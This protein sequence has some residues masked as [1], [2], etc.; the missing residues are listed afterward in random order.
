MNEIKDLFR[1]VLDA[2][3]PPPPTREAMLTIAHTAAARRRVRRA[4]AGMSAVV[5][6]TVA[7]AVAPHVLTPKAELLGAASARQPVSPREHG[8][9]M[10]RTLRTIVPP[11]FTTPSAD[12]YTDGNGSFPVRVT[13]AAPLQGPYGEIV[14]STDVYKGGAGGSAAVEVRTTGK[15]EPLGDLCVTGT[16]VLQS[17]ERGCRVITAANGLRVRFSWRELDGVGR[18]EYAACFHQGGYVLLQQGPAATRPDTEVLGR[19]WTE[20]QLADAVATTDFWPATLG[21]FTR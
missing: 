19:I 16:V 15:P 9:T 10:L 1:T 7:A 2:Q 21:P 18:I 17:P 6:L 13:Q 12:V 5:V 4:A 8:N 11:G 3:A 14:A 20:D